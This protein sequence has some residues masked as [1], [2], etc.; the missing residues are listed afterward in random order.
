VP[1]STPRRGCSFRLGQGFEGTRLA[2]RLLALAYEALVPML[3]PETTPPGPQAPAD[4]PWHAATVA[5]APYDTE[6]LPNV[7]CADAD[8]RPVCARLV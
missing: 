8:S 3:L 1:V 5:T 6:V 7:S 2:P 4:V